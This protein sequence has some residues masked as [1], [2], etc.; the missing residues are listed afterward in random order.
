MSTSQEALFKFVLE[1]KSTKN[2][3]FHGFFTYF[4]TGTTR[5]AVLA[6]DF[7]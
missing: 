4:Y 2:I 5:E 1:A 6:T 3:A 7:L